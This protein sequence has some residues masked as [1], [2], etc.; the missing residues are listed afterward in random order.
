MLHD[1]INRLQAELKAPFVGSVSIGKLF[2]L[3]GLVIVFLA[4]WGRIVTHVV[5]PAL[6]TLE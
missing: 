2:M 4:V 6:D 3:I 5:E 1:L